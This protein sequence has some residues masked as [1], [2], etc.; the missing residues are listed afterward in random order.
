MLVASFDPTALRSTGL[1]IV[2]ELW[3]NDFSAELSSDVHS[4]DDLTNRY[5]DDKHSW[6]VIIKQDSG[7][8]GEKQ[9][10]VKCMDKKEDL[11]IRGSELLGFLKNELR[12]RNQREGTNERSRLLRQPSH[13]ESTTALKDKEAD[14]RVLIAQHRGKK[15]NRRNVVE[16]GKS[17]LTISITN[18]KPWLISL[19]SA[20]AS[21]GT[22]K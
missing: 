14:V 19:F 12:E 16:A 5:K 10:K 1:Q 3:A 15:S 17:S 22:S 7:E 2:Q 13:P 18:T 21:S 11:D 4:P 6:F 9:L 8:F 20:P